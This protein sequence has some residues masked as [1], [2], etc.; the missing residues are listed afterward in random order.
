[1]GWLPHAFDTLGCD[2]AQSNGRACSGLFRKP[3]RAG[4]HH[5]DVYSFELNPQW[6]HSYSS[7]REMVVRYSKRLQRAMQRMVFSGGCNAWYT[8]SSDRNYKLWPY[9]ALRFLAE[10]W[11]PKAAEFRIRRREA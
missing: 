4:R 5:D 3:S 2:L 7:G 9:S 6:S 10:Q 8:D 1:V 11:K